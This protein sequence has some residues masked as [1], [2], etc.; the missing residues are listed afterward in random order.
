MP[1]LFNVHGFGPP[2]PFTGCSAWPRVDHGV[3]GR[4]HATRIATLRLAFASAPGLDP[5]ASPHTCTR[6]SI[7]QKVRRHPFPSLGIVLRPLVGVRFQ[8]LLTQLTAVLFIVQSPYLCAIGHR[9]VFSLGRWAALLHAEFHELRA[10]LVRLSTGTFS[11]R[12]RDFHPLWCGFPAASAGTGF[13][14]PRGALNPTPKGGLGYLRFR[15]PLLTESMLSFLSCGYLDVS[16][17]R[18]RPHPPMRSAVGDG[19]CEHPPGFPIRTP[20]DQSSF[21]SSPGL[22][23]GCRVLR[24]LSMPRHPPYTLNRLTTFI[25]HRP[26]RPKTTGG[27][28]MRPRVSPKRCPTTPALR[29]DKHS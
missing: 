15:S 22:F 26:S 2:T 11:L 9:G 25:D 21:A 13:V 18:V 23:A 5:L 17:P 3:S 29:K 6:R 27:A 24:R 28:A 14:T 1:E 4:T 10:T 20:P 8:V 12:V 16:V 7:M 19:C